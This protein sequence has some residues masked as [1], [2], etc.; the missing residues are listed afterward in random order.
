VVEEGIFSRANYKKDLDN[1]IIQAGMF[2]QK[3]SDQER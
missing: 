1:K 2:N 3:A